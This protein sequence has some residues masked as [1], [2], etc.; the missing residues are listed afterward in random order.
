M[1]MISLMG[2][3]G[4]VHEFR[5]VHGLESEYHHCW[6]EEVVEAGLEVAYALPAQLLE[7][8]DCLLHC[9]FNYDQQSQQSQ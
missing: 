3:D 1:I 7:I 2:S 5:E 8:S 4:L 6:D 9:Y